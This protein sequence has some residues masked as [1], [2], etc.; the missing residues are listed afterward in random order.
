M[1]T[2]VDYLNVLGGF[3]LLDDSLGTLKLVRIAEF[4]GSDKYCMEFHCYV[5][6]ELTR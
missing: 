5:Y 2:G 4:L 3:V 6:L 1:Y